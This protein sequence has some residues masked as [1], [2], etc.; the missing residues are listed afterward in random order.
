MPWVTQGKKPWE[1]REEKKCF[2][3]CELL[4]IIVVSYGYTVP[5]NDSLLLR[6]VTIPLENFTYFYDQ[7]K[8]G[9]FTRGLE[10]TQINKYYVV[11]KLYFHLFIHSYL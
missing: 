2:S 7:E 3:A 8:C 5:A 6:N 1:D 10:L 11:I 9:I 4:K